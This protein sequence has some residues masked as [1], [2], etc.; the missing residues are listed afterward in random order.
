MSTD[1]QSSSPDRQRTLF[2]EYCERWGL[3][4][5]G[6]YADEGVSATHTRLEDR[7]GLMALLA[8]APRR[9][10]ELVWC[11]D[12]N[13]VSRQLRDWFAVRAE[14]ARYGIAIVAHEGSNPHADHSTAEAEALDGTMA[15]FARYWAA[16]QSQLI[17]RAQRKL[18]G[19]GGY[20]G[21][22]L[23]LGLAWDKAKGAFV[24]EPTGQA[25]AVRA[26]ECFVEE[27]GSCHR[28][29]HRMVAE[30]WR[31]HRGGRLWASTIYHV[32][33]QPAYRGRRRGLGQEW[34]AA[35]P[36]VVPA[37]LVAA[38]DDLLRLQTG[39][40]QRTLHAQALFLGV[41]RC[42][43]C[44]NYLSCTN[45]PR[46][47]RGER[48]RYSCHMAHLIEP[49]CGWRRS[50]GESRVEEAIVPLLAET[51]RRHAET[52]SGP[53]QRGEQ[54]AR[55]RQ[56]KR[57][58]EVRAAQNRLVSLYVDGR[59]GQADYEHRAAELEARLAAL[60]DR[61]QAAP[62]V[63]TAQVRSW[64]RVLETQWPR[65]EL[66]R[67]RMLLQTLCEAIIPDADN[68]AASE[69]VWREGV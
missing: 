43:E 40:R 26:F 6:E 4:P 61:A 30:G 24:V 35:L 10:W 20:Q 53:Q 27:R 8:A 60:A 44:G 69:I 11:E 55:E 42:P 32:I 63:T 28:A 68:L 36:E 41:L 9:E 67:R 47:G 57:R 54:R 33:H 52:L 13:R 22:R 56:E 49:Q 51:L 29:A 59:I 39:K 38:A 12:R 16:Q 62:Q 7:A 23:P 48:R 3:V 17:R 34:P 65:L 2:A 31:G 64:A 45:R 18:L 58:A 1:K 19:E 46:V 50:I 25:F 5:A 14:L 15:V 37:A 66:Q 21:G